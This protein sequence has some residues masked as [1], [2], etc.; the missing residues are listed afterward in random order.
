M[1]KLKGVHSY[2]GDRHVLK[3]VSFEVQE[4]EIVTLLGR[5][6]AGKS[7]TLKTIMGLL[8]P[9]EGTI[10][11][12]DR[13]ITRMP[14]HLIS[15]L[16]GCVPQGRMVFPELSVSENLKA[17]SPTASLDKSSFVFDLFPLLNNR[18]DQSAGTLSGGERQ[19]L[20]VAMALV[21]KP[22]LILMDEPTEGLMPILV[23]K[24]QD[25]IRS[26][27][28]QGITVL[29][30]EQRVKMALETSTRA[31]IMENGIIRLEEDSK[32]LAGREDILQ[33]FVGVRTE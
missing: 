2:Y 19:A 9:R 8:K 23:S 12:Q 16:I 30:V 20:C 1:L 5:N 27:N 32:V 28:Q 24:L 25:T 14:P 6:G 17:A 10:T 31:I 18:L 7:T 11:F 15:R 21:N 29:L 33:R 22:R 13:D 26:I 3:G 4:G